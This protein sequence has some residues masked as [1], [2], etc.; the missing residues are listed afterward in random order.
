M[1]NYAPIKA[2]DINDMRTQLSQLQD[3]LQN[4]ELQINELAAMKQDN[5]KQS[6]LL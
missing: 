1:Q 3:A 5:S 6:K 4:V 2:S